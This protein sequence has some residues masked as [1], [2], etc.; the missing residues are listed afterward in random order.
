MIK[1]KDSHVDHGLTDLQLGYVIGQAEALNSIHEMAWQDIHKGRRAVGVRTFTIELPEWLGT[2]PCGLRGPIV[3]DPP[4]IDDAVVFDHRGDRKYPSR[5]V[6]MPPIQTNKVTVIAGPHD[7]HDLVLYTAFGGPKSP[8]EVGELDAI[9]SDKFGGSTVSQ[10]VA[11]GKWDEHQR[12]ADEKA[13]SIDFWKTHALCIVEDEEKAG[14]D[15]FAWDVRFMVH[16]T[17][18][19][20]GFDLTDDRA[21][22]MLSHDLRYANIGF[23]LGAKVLKTPDAERLAKTMGYN[24]ADRDA[25]TN[26][27]VIV[28]NRF[29]E[30]ASK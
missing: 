29:D 30:K 9:L 18:V 11:S 19:E 4:I 6:A 25:K 15:W 8:R 3:G 17:W 1:H 7:G 2:V 10:L 23:E 14:K 24:A 5:L 21:L 28:D 22:D 26:Y 27:K 16:K 20:D 12:L 13:Q